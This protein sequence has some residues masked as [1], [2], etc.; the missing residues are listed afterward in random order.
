LIVS[1][2]IG[3]QE[4]EF[5]APDGTGISGAVQEAGEDKWPVVWLPSADGSADFDDYIEY[6]G[7]SGTDWE[8]VHAMGEVVYLDDNGSE[9]L[10][11]HLIPDGA[12]PLSD[13]ARTLARR[14]VF[15]ARA[16]EKAQYLAD[17]LQQEAARTDTL[18]DPRTVEM[19]AIA[20]SLAETVMGRS[21]VLEIEWM[22]MLATER[23]AG[24]GVVVAAEEAE[25]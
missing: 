9:W 8:T 6:G 2:Y 13:K 15:T 10:G 16:F 3:S 4:I 23:A 21:A 5:V 12:E 18:N 7:P 14:D 20:E 1:H 11:R 25:A 22:Q 24:R 19:I 17:Y